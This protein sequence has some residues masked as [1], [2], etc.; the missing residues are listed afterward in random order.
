MA[1]IAPGI[2]HYRDKSQRLGREHRSKAAEP[3]FVTFFPFIMQGK[4]LPESL[5]RFSLSKD[6]SSLAL[7]VWESE[8]W[9]FHFL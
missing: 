7:G 8:F 1:A 6:R 5:N 2:M 9:P 4:E 3:C